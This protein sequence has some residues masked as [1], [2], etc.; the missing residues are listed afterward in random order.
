[1]LGGVRS[2]FW[3][4]RKGWEGLGGREFLLEGWEKLVGPPGGPGGV[5]RLSSKAGRLSSKAGRGQE[6]HLEGQ[7]GREYPQEGREDWEV[8]Q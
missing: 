8:R 3:I 2:L 5:G 6:S 4:A 1:M 7:G